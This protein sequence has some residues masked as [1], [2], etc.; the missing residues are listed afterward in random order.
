MT[1]QPTPRNSSRLPKI[2]SVP[3]KRSCNRTSGFSSKSDTH[4]FSIGRPLV[5]SHNMWAYQKP[6]VIA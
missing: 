5:N 2:A 3:E 1:S 4:F 6:F